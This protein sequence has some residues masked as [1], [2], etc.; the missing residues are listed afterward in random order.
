MYNMRFYQHK[1]YLLRGAPG[2]SSI[3]SFAYLVFLSKKEEK[4]K[5]EKVQTKKEYCC[6]LLFLHECVGVRV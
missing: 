1:E 6:F 4:S 3:F 5:K 2:I